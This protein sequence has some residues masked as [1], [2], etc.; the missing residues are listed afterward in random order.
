VTVPQTATAHTPARTG[1]EPARRRRPDDV[2]S[3]R[4]GD[5]DTDTDTDTRPAT[6]TDVA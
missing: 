1:D 3:D 6:D 5:T 4:P 2:E